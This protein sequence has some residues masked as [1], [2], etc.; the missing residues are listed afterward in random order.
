MT[1]EQN[2]ALKA[3]TKQFITAKTSGKALKPGSRT[4]SVLRQRSSQQQNTV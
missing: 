2:T 1:P 4:H 3:K